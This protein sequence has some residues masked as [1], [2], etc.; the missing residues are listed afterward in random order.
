ML[1][2]INMAVTDN[3]YN[4]YKKHATGDNETQVLTQIARSLK[5]GAEYNKSFSDANKQEASTKAIHQTIAQEMQPSQKNM[6]ARKIIK[7]SVLIFAAFATAASL[8]LL[9]I[10]PLLASIL[11]GI[12][13]AAF[14]FGDNFE[15]SEVSDVSDEQDL[16]KL[17]SVDRRFEEADA[18]YDFT[19]LEPLVRPNDLGKLNLDASIQKFM[20]NNGLTDQELKLFEERLVIDSE[21]FA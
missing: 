8:P 11:L 12:G 18:I 1:T 10:I 20:Q 14:V 6:Q 4:V 13:L 5:S 17:D 2:P 9:A 15:V 19:K 7:I 3:I 21:R 16:A